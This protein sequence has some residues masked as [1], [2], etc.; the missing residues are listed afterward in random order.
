MIWD[1]AFLAH[2]FDEMTGLTHRRV[3]HAAFSRE[4]VEVGEIPHGRLWLQSAQ[5]DLNKS[6][7]I[8]IKIF[9]SN[10]NFSLRMKFS[11]LW[12]MSHSK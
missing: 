4:E 10:E 2:C 12:Q 11:N 3:T 9:L 1:F 7:R 5:V 6:L 8:P